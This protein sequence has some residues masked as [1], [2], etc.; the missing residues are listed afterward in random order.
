MKN[1]QSRIALQYTK[2]HS[3]VVLVFLFFFHACGQ[4]APQHFFDS[5]SDFDDDSHKNICGETIKVKT[6]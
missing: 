4:A 1:K 3:F 2:I 6:K 5:P